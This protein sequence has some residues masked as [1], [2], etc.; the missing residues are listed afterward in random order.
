MIV[1]SQATKADQLYDLQAVNTEIADV[2]NALSVQSGQNIV[3]GSEVKGTITVQLK[4]VSFENALDYMV[5][6][7][8]YAYRK[9][10]PAY[11]VS[12]P[13]KLQSAYPDEKPEAEPVVTELYYANCLSVE[14]LKETLTTLVDGLSITVGPDAMMPALDS[15]SDRP[16]P[17]QESGGDG[18]INSYRTC[19]SRTLILKGPEPL[20]REAVDLAKRLD[21]PR[22]QVNIEAMILDV[23]EDAMKELGV[24]WKWNTLTIA[25]DTPTPGLIKFGAFSRSAANF[26]A[27]VSAML[28]S[29]KAHILAKP[30]LSVIDSEKANI[31]IGE[32]LLYPILIGYTQLGTPIFDKEEERVGIYLQVVPRIGNDGFITLGIYPQVSTVTGWLDT[33]VGSYPQISTREAQTTVRVRTGERIAIGGLVREEEIQTMSRIP[34]LSEIPI[35]GELFKYRKTSKIKSEIVII[36]TPQIL[37]EAAPEAGVQ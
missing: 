12:T 37:S 2:L 22:P 31:L 32:R 23:S 19:V 8:G 29:G 11:L 28:K 20:V 16:Y 10:G 18:G 1:C 6:M 33:D 13:E 9:E 25:E 30:N 14:K 4:Q 15:S 34:L 7:H 17:D 5:R 3:V 21:T 36:I 35:L 27:T 24:Q 26:D